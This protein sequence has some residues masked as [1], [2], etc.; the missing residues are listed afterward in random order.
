MYFLNYI[1]FLI[2]TSYG[3]KFL[4][5][6]QGIVTHPLNKKQKLLFTGPELFWTLTF[7]TGLLA[8]SAP[9][10][11]DLM[12]L[13]LMVLEV[14]C[15][16]GL[17]VVKNRPVWAVPIIFYLLYILW[18]CIGLSYTPSTSYGI[19]VILKY[20]YPLVIMLVSSAIVRNWEVAVKTS[21]GARIVAIVSICVFFIPYIGRMFPGVFWYGTA[22]AINYISMCIL[23]LALYFHNGKQKKDL[24]LTIVFMIP[25]ILWVFRTSIMGTTLALMSFFFFRYKLKALPVMFIVIVMFISSIFFIP[26][27]KE[28]MFKTEGFS[29]EDLQ[30]GNISKDDIDSNGRFAMWDW[31]VEHFYNGKELTGSGTGNLQEIFY[32]LKHPFGGIKI[33]HNDYVQMLCD[34]GIIGVMLFGLSFLSLIIHCFIVYN[35]KKNSVAIRIFAITAGS[36]IAGVLLTM[37]TDNVI[38]YSM[39]T[40]SY[41]CGFYGM[42]LGLLISEKNKKKYA[43]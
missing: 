18:L 34:N 3:L 21:L 25:C 35:N 37:Y 23:S 8:L 22:A 36:S 19:R 16:I 9:A 7:S 43:V 41:P 14:F 33:V 28:K 40:I 10:G 11:L 5:Q 17:F 1:Y 6:K 15:I 4:F 20:I 29:V 2:I 26:S 24:I 39:A 42:M 12:A 30:K 13:R 38:N 27:V 32:S 31:S